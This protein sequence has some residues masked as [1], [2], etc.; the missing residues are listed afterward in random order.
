[1][2]NMTEKMAAIEAAGHEPWIG[3]MT[4]TVTAAVINW[5]GAGAWRGRAVAGGG[6]ATCSR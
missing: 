2:T 5:L 4:L 6:V 3:S 1:M